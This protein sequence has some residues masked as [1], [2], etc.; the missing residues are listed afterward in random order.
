MSNYEA[1]KIEK[2]I[3]RII[4]RLR[5]AKER[6]DYRHVEGYKSILKALIKKWEIEKGDTINNNTTMY[7][8][9]FHELIK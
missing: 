8:H 3:D 6:G 1:L 4:A 9:V 7:N 5:R 2:S